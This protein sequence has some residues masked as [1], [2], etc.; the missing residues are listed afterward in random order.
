MLVGGKRRLPSGSNE[1][2]GSH[3][4][5]ALLFRGALASGLGLALV[6]GSSGPGLALVP[7]AIPVAPPGAVATVGDLGSRPGAT[8]LPVNI[9][10]QVSASVDVGTGNL[11]ISVTAVSLPG[12]NG[13]VPL[14]V[15]YNSESTDT[16]GED[17]AARWT[18]SLGG[19]GSVSTTPSGVLHTAGDGY[20][21]L[22]TPVA[23]STTAFTAPAGTKADLEKK[24][25]GSYILTSRTTASVV[26]FNADGRVKSLADRNGNTTTFAPSTGR[27][28]DITAT[29]GVTGARS[30]H[31]SY[32]Y[33]TGTLSGISQTNGAANRSVSFG[34]DGYGNLSSFT[35]LAGKTTTFGYTGNRVTTITP[36]AGGAT[37]LTY[38]ASGRVVQIE[39]VNTSAGSPGNSVTRLAYP[40]A[41]QTLVAG[42]NTDPAVPVGSGPRTTYTLN[43]DL[44]V[45]AATDPMGRPGPRPIP[46]TSTP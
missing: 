40:S 46:G 27:V 31:L 3:R 34:P 45:T 35:D 8:R 28:T 20:S 11:M 37:K 1:V 29:K 16:V 22:F 30:A 36:P 13:G 14:G 41:T 33:Y 43:G 21:S 24:A 39:R 44:R 5:P 18:L 25:D 12:I 42:P 6:A 7:L 32:D 10:D 23:G 15:V 9:S 26:G 17:V 19:A 38:D 4:L 2:A